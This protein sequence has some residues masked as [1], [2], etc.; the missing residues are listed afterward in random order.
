[1]YYP[2]GGR[3]VSRVARLATIT[4]TC[5]WS[6]CA[7]TWR[8]SGVELERPDGRPAPAGDAP[9]KPKPPADR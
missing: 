9:R 7:Y 1:V 4:V 8:D 3:A 5:T 6:D 2:R